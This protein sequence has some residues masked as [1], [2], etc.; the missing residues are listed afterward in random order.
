M[1]IERE[2]TTLP[3]SL[4]RGPRDVPL[5]ELT[6]GE[7]LRRTVER[8]GDREALVVREQGY[9]ATYRELW[10]AGRRSPPAAC[11]P[12]ACARATAW[13]SGR[14]T[15]TSGSSPSTPPRASARSS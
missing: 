15:A 2:A 14:P 3:L 4:S 1:L 5:L 7:S 12:A 8:F 13:A 10:D 6:I 9:R 11:S